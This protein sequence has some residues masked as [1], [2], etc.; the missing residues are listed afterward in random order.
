MSRKRGRKF[1]YPFAWLDE[2]VES[3]LN[4]EKEFAGRL[5]SEELALLEEKFNVEIWE[6]FTRLK[7]E[8]FYLFSSKKLKATVQRYNTL[9]FQLKQ[10]A[11]FNQEKYPEAG[12]LKNTGKRV[13]KQLDA[14][15]GAIGNRFPGC[16]AEPKDYKDNAIAVP[17]P[18]LFKIICGLSIDQMGIILKA[19]DDIKLIISRSLS[20]VFRTIVPY[21]S[22]HHKEELSWDSMRSN[23]YHPEER[24]K[25]VAIEALEKMIKKI[26]EYK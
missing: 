11:T 1:N 26:R 13:I 12:L 20:L 22:T 15:I 5:R 14:L 6:V 3:T 18:G 2:A 16:I 10:Q 19:A 23:S 8:T 17:D 9:L 21:L 7:S 24:D 25:E 4:P